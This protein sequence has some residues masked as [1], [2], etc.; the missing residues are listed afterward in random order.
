MGKSLEF[1]QGFFAN[2]AQ[3][4]AYSAFVPDPAVAE[5]RLDTGLDRCSADAVHA[6]PRIATIIGL[7]LVPARYRNPRVRWS[8]LD[9]AYSTRRDIGYPQNLTLLHVHHRHNPL[10]P[11][12]ATS[13]NKSASRSFPK[14]G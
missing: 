10:P 5:A 4:G 1:K 12:Q 11:T 6:G 13:C 9:S 3:E 14:A 8:K 2:S 7:T